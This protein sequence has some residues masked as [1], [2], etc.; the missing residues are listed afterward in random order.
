MHVF[1]SLTSRDSDEKDCGEAEESAFL[2]GDLQLLMQ[3]VSGSHIEKTCR[4]IPKPKIRI[5]EKKAYKN[6]TWKCPYSI[7]NIT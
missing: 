7:S 6:G 1:L 2:V 5:K 3:V 4:R